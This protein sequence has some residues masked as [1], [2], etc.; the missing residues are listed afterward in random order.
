LKGRLTANKIQEVIDIENHFD[1]YFCGPKPMREILRKSLKK[2]EIRIVGF[3][4][5]EFKF[6]L[7]K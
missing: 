1:I 5:E 4:F 7:S 6:G 2:T 3:H